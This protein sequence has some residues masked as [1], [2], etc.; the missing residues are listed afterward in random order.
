MEKNQL[1]IKSLILAAL[2]IPVQLA[3]SQNTFPA[4]GNASIASVPTSSKLNIYNYQFGGGTKTTVSPGLTILNDIATQINAWPIG[5]NPNN[6]FEVLSSYR[7]GLNPP[8]YTPSFFIDYNGHT[9]IAG[10][11][12]L[13]VSNNFQV[14][15]TS[16]VLQSSLIIGSVSAP[17]GYKLYVETGILTEKVKVAVKSTANWSDFVFAKDYKLKTL[18][19][20]D[21]FITLNKHLPGVPSAEEVVKS[22]IDVATMD[23]KLLEKIEEITL[24]MI[25]LKKES[26][27]L[28]QAVAHLKIENEKLKAII[29]Q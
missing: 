8:I 9:N 3:K 11:K 2:V 18:E 7:F 29:K 10:G 17:A 21:A 19:E 16:A 25:D 5:F 27:A 14:G 15:P 4:T 13:Y 23:A 6:P 22:G 24:Y 12:S 20:V 26:E 28:K 1:F